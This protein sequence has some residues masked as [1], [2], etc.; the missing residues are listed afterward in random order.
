MP[1][2]SSVVQ[3]YCT[4]ADGLVDGLP[5]GGILG[6]D[7]FRWVVETDQLML[8]WTDACARLNMR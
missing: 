7:A 6:N 4:I 8:N 2:A 5:G 1:A 3:A